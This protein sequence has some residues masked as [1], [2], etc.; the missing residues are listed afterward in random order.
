MMLFLLPPPLGMFGLLLSCYG[1]AYL[2][3]CLSRLS[4]RLASAE[5]DD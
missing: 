5:G 1:L 3:E 4:Y 2:G